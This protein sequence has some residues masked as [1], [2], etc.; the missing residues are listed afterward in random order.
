VATVTQQDVIR[1]IAEE[2]AY[3]VET[4]VDCWMT[5]IESA[6]SDTKLSATARLNAVHEIVRS[7]KLITGKMEFD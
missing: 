1:A 7:Y 4:A 6:L 5:Q 3:G 2:M